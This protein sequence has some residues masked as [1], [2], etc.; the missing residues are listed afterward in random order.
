M[1]I[2]DVKAVTNTWHFNILKPMGAL[3]QKNRIHT[4]LR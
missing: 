2:M 1:E 3:I 4:K